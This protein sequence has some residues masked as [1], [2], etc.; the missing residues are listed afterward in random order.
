[1]N[2]FEWSFSGWLL[3]GLQRVTHIPTSTLNLDLFFLFY[4]S[5]GR[6]SR[7]VRSFSEGVL[8]TTPY[9]FSKAILISI[10]SVPIPYTGYRALAYGI[11]T[12]MPYTN[13][14]NRSDLSNVS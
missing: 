2:G 6:Y 5:N 11:R 13:F 1:M 14:D 3:L 10:D 9:P 7:S 4:T 8:I 12:C